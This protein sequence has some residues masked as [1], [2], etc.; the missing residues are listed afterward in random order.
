[1]NTNYYIEMRNDLWPSL[2]M[3]YESSGFLYDY[4]A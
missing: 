4:A 2:E 3:Y 1:M